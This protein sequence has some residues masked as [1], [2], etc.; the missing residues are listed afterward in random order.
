M[1]RFLFV[2]T[3]IS[4]LF[5]VSTGSPIIHAEET[6][7]NI[8]KSPNSKWVEVETT[9]YSVHTYPNAPPSTHENKVGGYSGTLN[10][11]SYV[12]D[13][14][15]MRW[16]AWYSGTVYYHKPIPPLNVIENN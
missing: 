3:L 16:I 13:A 14:G 1:K 11:D 15:N 2:L 7:E 9:G 12:L 4:P 5:F 6:K 8:K 10:L